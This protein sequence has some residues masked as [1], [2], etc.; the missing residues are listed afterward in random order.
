MRFISRS[1]LLIVLPLLMV[2]CSDNTAKVT[3]NAKPHQIQQQ[4]DA[5][6][7]QKLCKKVDL[8]WLSFEGMPKLNKMIQQQLA[9]MLSPRNQSDSTA[10]SLADVADQFM[11]PTKNSED[12]VIRHWELSG[13]V[14]LLAHQGR[15]ATFAFSSYRYMGGAHGLP[16][17][18]W[19]NWDLQQAKPVSLDD[20]LVSGKKAAFAQLA[21]QAYN[22]W[23]AKTISEPANYNKF[24]QYAPSPNYRLTDK[25]LE[26]LYQP[27][28]I[29]P[30]AM[31]MPVLVIPVASIKP[32]VKPVYQPASW[33]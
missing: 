23:V 8:Q 20:V 16:A 18:S 26:L 27:Y 10:S 4:S 6:C 15:I 14:K 12:L 28:A 22:D 30:Y 7:K 33:Q 3:L 29:A 13:K 24:W 31:G 9:L 11:A 2:A 5:D 19:L 1:L 32:L 21:T 25:G 17:K